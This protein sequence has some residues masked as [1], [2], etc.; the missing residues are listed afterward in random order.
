MKTLEELHKIREEKRKELLN[1]NKEK[2]I[3]LIHSVS[4]SKEEI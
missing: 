3:E 1:G 2:I 4:H